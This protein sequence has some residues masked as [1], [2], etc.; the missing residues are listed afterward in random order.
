MNIKTIV[1]FE[2]FNN[3]VVHVDNLPFV[4]LRLENALSRL[5]VTSSKANSSSCLH[6]D[7]QLILAFD[8]ERIIIVIDLERFAA[9]FI[10][11]QL[12]SVNVVVF[13]FDFRLLEEVL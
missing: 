13:N 5:I 6:I 10:L 7:D 8:F 2:S 3:N 12:D 9:I 4:T 1:P 11:A